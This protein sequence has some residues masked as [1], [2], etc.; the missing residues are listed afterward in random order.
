[1]TTT[2]VTRHSG[3]VDW[4]RQ[5]SH[6]PLDSVVSGSFDAESVQP[7]DLVIGT[8]PAQ[9][10]ARICERGGR[11]RHLTLDLPEGLRGVELSAEDMRACHARLEEFHIQ[12]SSVRAGA[13]PADALNVHI[14]LASGENLPNLIPALARSL[15]AHRV[16]ILASDAMRDN[17]KRL[18]NGFRVAG[19]AENHVRI[20]PGC[21]DHDVPTILAWARRCA[22]D[23]AAE[24]PAAR[25]ILNLTGGNKLMTIAFLQAFR[26]CAEIIYCDTGNDRIDYFHPIGQAAERLPVNLLKLRP[27]LAVQGYQSREETPDSEGIR[28]RGD[29]TRALVELAPRIPN[30]LGLLN[31]A[32]SCYRDARLDRAF[33]GQPTRSDEKELVDLMVE[34]GLL[35]AT[36]SRLAIANETASI[37]L[38]GGWLEEWCWLIGKKL[39]EGESGK[40][41]RVDRWGINLKIDRCDSQTLPRPGQYALNELDAVFI[42]RNR[43]LLIECKSGA[44]VSERGK[45]QDILNKLETLGKHVGGRLDTKWLLTARRIEPNSQAWQRAI[46]YQITIVPPQE[47]IKLEDKIIGWMTR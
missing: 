2:F 4:A 7:G 13:R 17:A 45:S 16:L 42:H 38:G 25:L 21:P 24:F 20:R 27:Y 5:E 43:M 47:L 29:L 35:N 22:D 9:I 11:Y 1:M 18:Q 40:R 37:Y 28:G 44:Q 34:Q 12:R 23:I 26:P 14:V 31:S 6:L 36:G 46:K 30:L 33:V 19:L 41:L 8:L 10:A 3:A 39:E 32:A 15:K